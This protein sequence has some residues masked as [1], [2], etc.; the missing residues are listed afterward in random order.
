LHPRRRAQD[1]IHVPTYTPLSSAF[2]RSSVEHLAGVDSTSSP[3]AVRPPSDAPSRHQSRPDILFVLAQLSPIYLSLSSCHARRPLWHVNDEHRFSRPCARHLPAFLNMLPRP[4][5][6][7]SLTLTSNPY[8][9][10]STLSSG[11]SGLLRPKLWPRHCRG[12]RL[13][14]SS[15]Q[16]SYAL[17]L[18]HYSTLNPEKPNHPSISPTTRWNRVAV[19]S[20]VSVPARVELSGTSSWSSPAHAKLRGESWD[21]PMS[22]CTASSP[23]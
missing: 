21:P 6:T 8:Q 11:L 9:P 23:S 20:D 18:S 1:P 22:S 7:P 16:T 3:R 17:S 19:G 15:M 10:A 2:L 14:A 13:L 12:H 5:L 4:P